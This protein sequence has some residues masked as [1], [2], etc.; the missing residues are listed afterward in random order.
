MYKVDDCGF[1]FTLPEEL[2]EDISLY[3][4]EDSFHRLQMF[5]W[6]VW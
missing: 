4:F 2:S 3:M 1:G 6:A 5:V